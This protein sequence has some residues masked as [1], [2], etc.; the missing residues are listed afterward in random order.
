MTIV[1]ASDDV[2]AQNNW[3][4]MTFLL[5]SDD[6]QKLYILILKRITNKFSFCIAFNSYFNKRLI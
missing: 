5:A 6:G 1:L 3:L 4:L 2:F